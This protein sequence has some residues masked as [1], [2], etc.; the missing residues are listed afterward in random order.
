MQAPYSYAANY[1][2]GQSSAHE[3][4]VDAKHVAHSS[5]ADAVSSSV[6][7][8]NSEATSSGRAQVSLTS[9]QVANAELI[10]RDKVC[11]FG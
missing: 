8:Y 7:V 9:L 4:P 3:M 6:A 10:A 2:T 5:A 11:G 1:S